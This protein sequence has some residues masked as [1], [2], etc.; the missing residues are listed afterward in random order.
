VHVFSF[1]EP[2]PVHR[3]ASFD[4]QLVAPASHEQPPPSTWP[5]LVCDDSAVVPV[6]RLKPFIEQPFE[7]APVPPS[8]T[9][10][11]VLH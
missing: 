8:H 7:P 5:Q 4:T 1:C 11:L 2:D 3:P 6:Q 9:Q 10:P